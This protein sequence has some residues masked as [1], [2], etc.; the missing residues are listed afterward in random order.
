MNDRENQAFQHFLLPMRII[1]NP[2]LLLRSLHTSKSWF[3]IN[4]VIDHVFPLFLSNGFFVHHHNSHCVFKSGTIR[5]IEPLNVMIKKQTLHFK[6]TR[7]EWE[8]QRPSK[9]SYS[10]KSL[11]TCSIHK[12]TQWMCVFLFFVLFRFHSAGQQR[13]WKGTN[14]ATRGT[15][16]E[17]WSSTH[18]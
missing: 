5:W 2:R 11:G 15:V 7:K 6:M 4:Q 10:K 8:E 1:P 12:W 18:K 14:M 3:L 9:K 13:T 17:K 16:V